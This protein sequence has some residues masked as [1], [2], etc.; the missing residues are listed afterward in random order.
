MLGNS[1]STQVRF[2]VPGFLCSLNSKFN[3]MAKTKKVKK[4]TRQ[5][6]VTVEEMENPNA[7]SYRIVEASL[8]DDFCNY[9]FEV[10][11]GVGLGQVHSVTDKKNIID[12][13]LRKAFQKFRVHLAFIDDV[14]KIAG[15]NVDDIDKFHKHDHTIDYTVSGFKM[16]SRKGYET[17]QLIGEKHVAMGWEPIETPDIILDNLGGYQW[18]NELLDAANN[19]REEVAL[20][21]EGKCTPVE[22]PKE[23][24]KDKDQGDLFG[25][26]SEVDPEMENAL[27]GAKV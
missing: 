9:K 19:A 11:K 12:E 4:G 16:K 15:I 8:K 10:L 25:Q 1:K 20:Y 14:F 23:E 17:I 21:G 22:A 6:P 2:Y 7:R 3:Y 13:D 5:N 26:Q 24:P 27:E 18:Y